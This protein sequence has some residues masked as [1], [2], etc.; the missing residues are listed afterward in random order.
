MST[1]SNL[2]AE[3]VFSEHPIGL[4]ALDDKLDY[5][6][7]ITE[8]QREIDVYWDLTGCIAYSGTSIT[9]EPFPDSPTTIL[10]G[11]VPSGSTNDIIIVSPNLISL[12]SLD[13]NL[14]SFS[15]GGYVFCDSAYLQS[16]SIGY[17]YTDPSTSLNVVQT[18]TFQTNTTQSWLFISDTFEVPDVSAEIRAYLK[19][20]TLSGGST[21]EA[22]RFYVNG[23]SVGQWSEEFNVKSLGVHTVEIPSYVSNFGGQNAIEATSYGLNNDPGYYIADTNLL[24]RNTS[25][26]L[27][28][29]A[30]NVTK[31]SHGLSASLIIPGKGFL[32]KKGQFL[33]YT[34][35]FWTRIS[36]NSYTD[37]RIFGPIASTDGLY[38]NGGFL[39]LVIG[40]N[41]ASHF[42][43]EWFRPML[44]Q[45]RLIKDSASLLINGEQV[46]SFSLN[47]NSLILPNEL[48]ENGK[49][50]DWLGFYA[51]EDVSPF[52][53]DCVA[54][55]PYQVPITVAK[56]RWVYGQAV[57]SPESINSAYNGTSAFIDYP[58]ADY[59]SNYSY[60]NLA[61]WSQG[62]FDNLGTT[63]TSL[64]TPNYLLPE[65]FTGTKTI[66]QLYVDNQEIQSG[67]YKFITFN[68]NSEWD[69]NHSYINFNSF[70]V[71]NDEV[72]AIFGVFSSENLSSEETL[73]KIY[74]SITGN[75]FSVRKDNDQIYYYMNYN[76][77]EEQIYTSDPITSGD[78][79][80]AGLIIDKL[81]SYFGGNVST[82][83]GNRN[84]LK[85]YVAGEEDPLYSFTG[86]MYS[87]G[88]STTFNTKEIENHFD[89]LTG[90]LPIDS[91][92]E[93][94]NHT[95][96]YTLI[97]VQEYNSYYLD[98]A[99]FGYWEDYVPLSYF[100]QYIKDKNGID[101]YDVDF[102]QF[103]IDYPST[104]TIGEQITSPQKYY[105]TENAFV[106]TY[107]TFQYISDGANK[108][109]SSFTTVEPIHID[110][111]VDIDSYPNWTT[112]KFE[113]MDGTVIY[114]SK[115]IDFN[116]LAV[117]THVEFNVKG[118]I[119]KPVQIKKLEIISQAL[120][121][122]SFN[123]IGTRFGINLF[124]Y[125]KSGIYFDYKTKNPFSIYKGSSPYLY[126]TKDSGI[127]IRGEFES[128]ISR[129][130]AISINDSKSL[131]YQVN[132][133]QL[134][135]KYDEPEFPSTALEL[136]EV[137]HKTDTI[138]FYFVADTTKKNRGTIY[139]RSLLTGEDFSGL[140]YYVNGNLVREPK[141]NLGEWLS[142]GISFSNS[143][144]FDS[145]V[146]AI[147]LNG[148]MVFN[149]ISYYQANSLQQLQKYITR[150]W[151][152]I[153]ND[154]LIDLDWQYWV[155][156]YIWQEVL[157]IASSNLYA[158]NPDEI[159]KAYIGTNK[160]I[161]DDSEG[162][163][164]DADKITVY[165]D[166]VWQTIVKT[167]V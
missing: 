11:D 70:N 64:T 63:T 60:P 100:G 74:N 158:T 72:H 38:V 47:T 55:Y 18:K 103:N 161:V 22:Y 19:I 93:I 98:I 1:P 128:N 106:K 13:A 61:K 77:V 104:S 46:I 43:G 113:V 26:P 10:E 110:N 150:P 95:A 131:T 102:L 94:I 65:I 84:G 91:A 79:F 27:V 118:I 145:Y 8:T 48:D 149:N 138:K 78:I 14:G 111:I 45:I 133:I 41:F 40:N 6:S 127:K 21:T 32:N 58:F 88:F 67:Q 87:F 35:E 156:D 162:M 82:F 90:I 33:D 129:G 51:H 89:Q 159:Y 153:K 147:N 12:N 73:F 44:I 28:F 57:V 115:L 37:K 137:K 105:S 49:N 75:Y 25:L 134:W 107:I 34:V 97:P 119:K 122:N 146:G 24:A 154:G 135:L 112:T 132:A 31:L 3:K 86:K 151:I 117:V 124:P 123:P 121:S 99:S 52:E 54:I 164:F 56:R 85:L 59:T 140:A 80:S 108:I 50:Q 142:L 76:G 66:D 15:V 143:L 165:S 157:V 20:T 101:Y 141:I 116:D 29:G 109:Q 92:S 163:S 148:P 125:K 4:W 53:L 120:N 155:N 83:F 136:F 36:S 81:S 62:T 5:L 7:L 160:I 114:P 2:Y 17:E 68:P 71:I 42:V 126:L 139:A 152:K 39:T 130:I 144:N 23:I 166:T 96:S 69:N 9:D 30:A 16:I 167:P